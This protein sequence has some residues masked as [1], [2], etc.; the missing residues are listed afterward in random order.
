MV[1][2]CDTPCLNVDGTPYLAEYDGKQLSEF[3]KWAIKAIK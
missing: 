1:V 2:I 3:Q